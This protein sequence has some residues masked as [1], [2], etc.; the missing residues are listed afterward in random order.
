MTAKAVL[1]GGEFHHLL[2]R[3]HSAAK[4]EIGELLVAEDPSGLSLLQVTDL[5]YGSQLSQQHLELVSGMRLEEDTNFSL[6]DPELRTYG[7]LHLKHLLRISA[8]RPTLAKTLPPF[9]SPLRSVTP[10]DLVF[11]ASQKEGLYLGN[12]RS[13]TTMLPLPIALDI[14][15]TLSHH[16]LV[17]ATTGRGKSNLTATIL[18]RMMDKRKAGFLVLD[19]HDEYYGRN[20]LGLKDHPEPDRLSYYTL[21]QV[22]HGQHTLKIGLSRLSPGDFRGVVDWSDPQR[23]LLTAYSRE[24]GQRWIEAVVK[25]EPLREDHLVN[26]MTRNVVKRRLMTLLDLSLSDGELVCRGVFDATAG[27]HTLQDIT[28]DLEDAKIV[29]IDT[30]SFSGALELLIGSVVTGHLYGHYRRAKRKGTLSDKPVVSVVLEEAPR[31][32]GREVLER[33]GNIFSTIAR[34]GRKFRVGLFAITQL[35]SLIPREILA[36][37]NTKIILGIEMQPEREAI[38]NS[39]AHDLSDDARAIA[40]LDKGEAIV[41]SNFSVFAVPVKI[42]L[43]SDTVA[44]YRKEHEKAKGTTYPSGFSDLASPR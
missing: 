43:F 38:I 20:G 1:I 29:V 12:L 9:F 19:P 3:R 31:V 34:E 4:V 44:R 10:E 22:P 23:D 13:G 39:A 37:M 2:A 42:P 16:V 28:A 36:N 21:H 5:S 27:E 26:E 33:G 14:E 15:K 40:S 30:S 7:L 32:L 11:L 24:K 17:P 41:T 6:Q 8:G 25:E 18:F 35:P